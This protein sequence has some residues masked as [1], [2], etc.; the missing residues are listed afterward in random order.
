MAAQLGLYPN[1]VGDSRN[2]PPSN[3][4]MARVVAGVLADPDRRRSPYRITGPR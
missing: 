2:A 1:F 3:D 4:D